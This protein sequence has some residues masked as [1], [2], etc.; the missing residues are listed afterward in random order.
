M[1]LLLK[2]SLEE[3]IHRIADSLQPEIRAAFFDAVETLKGT[4]PVS[5]LADLL[6]EGALGDALETIGQLGLTPEQ[7]APIRE[8][9]Q[10]ATTRAAQITAAEYGLAFDAVNQRAVTFATEQAGKLITG[11]DTSTIDAIGDVIVRGQRGDVNVREQ[12]RLIREMVGLTSRD[13][14]AVDRFYTGLIENGWT[15]ARARTAMERMSSRLLRRR[16]E[17]I[18]RTETIRA[19]NMGT[20]LGWLEAQDKG[21]LPR[22]GIG[23]VWIATT[24]SRTC[25]ICAVLDG[26]LIEVGG[27]FVVEERA[28]SFDISGETISVAS[29]VPLKKPTSTRTPPAHPSCR[30]TVGIEM[31]DG[32]EV[33]PIEPPPEAT[34]GARTEASMRDS[35]KSGVKSETQMDSISSDVSLVEFNDGTK[36]LRRKP[37]FDGDDDPLKDHLMSKLGQEMD[38]RT[39]GVVLDDVGNSYM[40]WV[41]DAKTWAELDASQSSAAMREL[42]EGIPIAERR[43]NALFDEITQQA[44]RHTRNFIQ[45]SQGRTWLIDNAR[46]QFKMPGNQG[47]ASSAFTVAAKNE[48]WVFTAEELASV[49]TS[50]DN[51]KDVFVEAGR[52]K[53]WNFASRRLNQ[54]VKNPEITAAQGSA[55]LLT[56]LKP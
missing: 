10:E 40:E 39:P 18:A 26:Q 30:C 9:I 13:A 25:P 55:K 2:E 56:W 52:V 29:T 31:L 32:G 50:L 33:E 24:D 35:L 4:L 27:G 3:R 20:E 17:N 51:V 34:G 7:L 48:G 38:I 28:T 5:A 46:A 49:R 14:L 42:W 45:D 11:V 22:Q 21:L 6:D 44:D 12:A 36:A 15:Q 54:L 19:A 1:T 16:A 8:A 37:V 53:D 43:T 47:G 23:K 41:P